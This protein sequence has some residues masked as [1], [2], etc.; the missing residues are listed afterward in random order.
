MVVYL[1]NSYWL[2]SLADFYSFKPNLR[3][4]EILLIEG[5]DLIADSSLNSFILY[6][7]LCLLFYLIRNSYFLWLAIGWIVSS[8]SR[9]YND[10]GFYN[11]SA[12]A[13]KL[14]DENTY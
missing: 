11:S 12:F 13:V 10:T 3:V 14:W 7:L 1:F 9:L 8:D 4:E 5:I 2:I 6:I